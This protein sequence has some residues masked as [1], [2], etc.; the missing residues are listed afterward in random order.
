[1]CTPILAGAHDAAE[2]PNERYG[3]QKTHDPEENNGLATRLIRRRPRDAPDN[4]LHRN[5]CKPNRHDEQAP[6]HETAT[7]A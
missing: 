1:V 4:G 7:T 3:N 2:K 5:P 6:E